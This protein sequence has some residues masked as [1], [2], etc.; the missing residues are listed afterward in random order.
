MSSSKVGNVS[1]LPADRC[2]LP[3]QSQWWVQVAVL[4]VNWTGSCGGT[5]LGQ[6][7]VVILCF[8]ICE[9]H[10]TKKQEAELW[11]M[12]FLYIKVY[13]VVQITSPHLHCKD[14]VWSR[15][16][17]CVLRMRTVS[18]S[19]FYAYPYCFHLCPC[20]PIGP[21]DS[22]WIPGSSHYKQK[23]LPLYQW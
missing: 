10:L 6:Y 13:W 17:M 18:D 8:Y 7:L 5:S 16:C 21:G 4:T 12:T 3:G 1:L 23:D 20:S 11:C 14:C 22:T 2:R 9:V 19:Q 15:I